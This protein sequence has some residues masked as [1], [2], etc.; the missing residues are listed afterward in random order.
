MVARVEEPH[1]RVRRGNGAVADLDVLGVG[2]EVSRVDREPERTRDEHAVQVDLEPVGGDDAHALPEPRG[3]VAD[4]ARGTRARPPP[5]SR[6][7]TA[8]SK[9][10]PS[11]RM[12]T[13]PN[14]RSAG[15]GYAVRATTGPFNARCGIPAR[16]RRSL[17]STSNRSRIK[18]TESMASCRRNASSRCSSL[19]G[20]Q[21]ASSA[22]SRW[23]VMRSWVAASRSAAN[24]ESSSVIGAGGSRRGSPSA[25]TSATS[26]SSAAVTVAGAR[27][28]RAGVRAPRPRRTPAPSR[29]R[30]PH[31]RCTPTAS[32]CP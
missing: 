26:A 25:A 10:A 32:R 2:E 13:S 24:V 21:P 6:C 29:R 14:E 19:A 4:A 16:V 12:S 17:V 8:A 27:G 28:A 7:A 20:S 30:R 22:R 3:E 23:P 5:R 11:T 31:R 9:W 18:S 15:S 1:V